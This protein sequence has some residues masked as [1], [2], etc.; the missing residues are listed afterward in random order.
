MFSACSF[1]TAASTASVGDNERIVPAAADVAVD[2]HAACCLALLV[3]A[4]A[5]ADADGC[6]TARFLL[7]KQHSNCYSI[8]TCYD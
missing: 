4:E 5:D 7:L 1:L 2:G 3:V 8:T 6:L